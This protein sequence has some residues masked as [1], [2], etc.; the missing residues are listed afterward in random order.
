MSR[1]Y[2]YYVK[3][4]T[5]AV[6]ELIATYFKRQHRGMP[7]PAVVTQNEIP[8]RDAFEVDEGCLTMLCQSASARDVLVYFALVGETECLRFDA[9]YQKITKREAQLRTDSQAAA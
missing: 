5:A 2:K 8:I 3:P 9:Y 7:P 1:Q 4:T 6:K